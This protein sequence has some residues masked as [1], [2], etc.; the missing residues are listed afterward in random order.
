[1]ASR[2]QIKKIKDAMQS[3]KRELL[4]LP[5]QEAKKRAE[6]S[7][8]RIGVLDSAGKVSKYYARGFANA[9]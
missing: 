6:E 1:M 8:T 2:A 4:S 5:E 7:L 3:E 9:K